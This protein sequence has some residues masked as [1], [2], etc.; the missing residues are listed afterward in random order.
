MFQDINAQQEAGQD[1]LDNKLIYDFNQILDMHKNSDL[2][3]LENMMEELNRKSINAK[4]EKE[5]ED[6]ETYQLFLEI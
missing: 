1:E 3:N 6:W 4:E 2:S 5:Q